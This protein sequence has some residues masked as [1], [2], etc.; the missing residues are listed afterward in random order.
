MDRYQFD[1]AISAYI[2]NELDLQD[3]RA[4]EAYMDTN[5]EAKILVNE[6]KKNIESMKGMSKLNVS[7]DFMSNL[8]RRIEFEKNRPSKKIVNTPH[9]TLFGFSPL[10][11]GI[12]A[13][14]VISFITVG[15]NFWSDLNRNVQQVPLYS[16]NMKN[17]QLDLSPTPN[18]TKL[19]TLVSSES[20]VDSSD[21]TIIDKKKFKLDDKVKFVKD[22]R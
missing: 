16:G 18:S 22:Q 9:K 2:D 13:V 21:T 6:I 17:T 3:R 1:D 8:A 14:I 15:V 5:P 11:G 20:V 19:P 7:G 10:N 4:F 12:M